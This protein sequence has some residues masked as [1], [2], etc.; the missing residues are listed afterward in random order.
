MGIR[1]QS[2]RLAACSQGEVRTPYEAGHDC[3]HNAGPELSDSALLKYAH[4]TQVKKKRRPT[5]LS[6]A[7]SGGDILFASK[8][9]EKAVTENR[10]PAKM[11]KFPVGRAYFPRQRLRSSSID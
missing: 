2:S 9:G 4:V 11:S 6:Q 5:F 8:L 3:C 10:S 1:L 7:R